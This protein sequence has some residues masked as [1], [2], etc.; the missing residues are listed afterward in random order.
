MSTKRFDDFIDFV[1]EWE[2]GYDNDPDDPGGETKYGIDKRSHPKEN[3]KSL[4]L[5]RAKEIYFD[6][7]WRAGGVEKMPAKLGEVIFNCRVN[8]GPGRVTKI[9]AV[10]QDASEFIEEQEAF[11]RRLA[12]ARPKSQKYLKGW[13]NRTRALRK[14]LGL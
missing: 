4:T 3:I 1:L 13:L 6:E 11:Y 9:L 14:R 10:T 7:Y 8:C 12:A 2:G 5:A